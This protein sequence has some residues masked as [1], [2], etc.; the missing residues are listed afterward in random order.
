MAQW[1]ETCGA[2]PCGVSPGCSTVRLQRA[3]HASARYGARAQ[4]IRVAGSDELGCRTR[5][6]AMR[7][8]LHTICAIYLHFM[9]RVGVILLSTDVLKGL[10]WFRSWTSKPGPDASRAVV[11]AAGGAGLR[12]EGSARKRQRS[13]SNV[14]VLGA[15]GARA[16]HRTDR[17]HPCRMR[18]HA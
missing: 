12:R 7:A 17:V 15:W 16:T 5:T 3:R 18:L 1:H 14:Y 8:D 2:A 10:C 9:R 6:I 13:M 11:S 4:M